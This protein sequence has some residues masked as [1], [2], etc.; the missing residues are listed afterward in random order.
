MSTNYT[1]NDDN[2][3]QLDNLSDDKLW[4]ILDDLSNNKSINIEEKI[5]HCCSKCK[6]QYLI[7]T[8]NRSSYVC[9]DCGLE[10]LEVLDES[11]EWSNY[12]DGKADSGKWSS[13]KCIFS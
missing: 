4:D 11:P 7:F 13:C 12:D 5:E 8:S 10:G 3:D 2:F 6:S 9:G 1:L